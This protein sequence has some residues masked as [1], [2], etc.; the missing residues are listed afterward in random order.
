MTQLDNTTVSETFAAFSLR[1]IFDKILDFKVVCSCMHL[2]I[3][4]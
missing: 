2:M 3:K 1:V 4:H